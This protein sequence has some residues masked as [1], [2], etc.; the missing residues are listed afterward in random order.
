M[1]SLKKRKI[2][3]DVSKIYKKKN[4]NISNIKKKKNNVTLVILKRDKV[5]IIK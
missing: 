4:I 2:Q 3:D 1:K 5:N